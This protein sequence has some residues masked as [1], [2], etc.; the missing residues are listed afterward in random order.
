MPPMNDGF[1][2]L[3]DGRGQFVDDVHLRD[4]LFLKVVRSPMQERVS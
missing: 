3:I 1:N 4:M 2:R